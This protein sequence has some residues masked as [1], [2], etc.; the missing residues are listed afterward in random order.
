MEGD[1]K[2]AL[3][4][5]TRADFMTELEVSEAVSLACAK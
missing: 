5:A 1:T 4:D 3:T 2:M